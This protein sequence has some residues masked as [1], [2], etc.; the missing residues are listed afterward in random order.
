MTSVA[1][2]QDKLCKPRKSGQKRRNNKLNML[3]LYY[4]KWKCDLYI[5]ITLFINFY[6]SIQFKI[7]QVSL[8]EIK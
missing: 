1:C 5:K 6:L 8:K 3:R 7:F 2:G 4:V